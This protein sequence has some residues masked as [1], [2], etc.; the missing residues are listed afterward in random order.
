MQ[1]GGILSK[2]YIVE[3]FKKLM[4]KEN[5][6]IIIFLVLNM[7]LYI[8]LF[9]GF[10]E[11]GMIPM[12]VVLYLLSTT[13]ALSPIGEFLLRVQSGAKSI[14]KI[15]K[16]NP[17]IEQRL[18]PLFER[19]YARAREVDPNLSP[20]IQLFVSLDKEPN[21]FATGRKTICV[22]QGLLAFTDAQIEGVLAHEFGHISHKDTDTLLVIM[23]SNL[24]LSVIFFFWRLVVNFVVLLVGSSSDGYTAIGRLI[25][26]IFVDLLL[27]LLIRLW[28]KIGTLLCMRSSRENE[29]AA[30]RFACDTGYQNEL[31]SALRDLGYGEQTAGF[32]A[33]IQASHPDTPSRLHR[34]ATFAPGGVTQKP[35]PQPVAA[36]APVP[37][38]IPFTPKDDGINRKKKLPQGVAAAVPGGGISVGDGVY[39]PWS[40][41]GWH[42]FCRVQGIDK[43]RADVLFYD[44]VREWVAHG[45]LVRWQ[46]LKGEAQMQ[47]NWENKGL[48]YV[49]ALKRVHPDGTAD[50]LYED[51]V[52]ERVAM[53]ALRFVRQNNR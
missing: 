10:S 42:Y 37:Q 6:G 23:V 22:T 9:G 8:F 35:Q 50:V 53:Q 46:G 47:G 18:V 51:G 2:I 7:A 17:D 3:Y 32:F 31:H 1:A 16:Y 49:C 44:G 15:A 27:V 34:I 12:A 25:V 5:I 52:S 43:G 48:F 41:D 40:G 11:P 20:K 36:G 39:A 4:R 30:D 24:L 26:H 19:V 29:Y 13:V 21:A 14:K 38:P 28:T 33:S 45:D